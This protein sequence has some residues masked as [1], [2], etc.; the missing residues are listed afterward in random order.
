VRRN[1]TPAHT[2]HHLQN[3]EIMKEDIR[4]KILISKLGKWHY[5]IQSIKGV[6]SLNILRR[7]YFATVHSHLQAPHTV[8]EEVMGKIKQYF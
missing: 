1:I 7:V 6:I 2:A 8:W 4:M 5:V 3:P